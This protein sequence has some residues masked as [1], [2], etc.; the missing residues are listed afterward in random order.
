MELRS[1]Y[2]KHL[3]LA[4]SI[5]F[6]LLGIGGVLLLPKADTQHSQAVQATPAPSQSIASLP[7]PKEKTVIVHAEKKWQDTGIEVKRNQSVGISAEGKVTWEGEGLVGPEGTWFRATQ[8]EGSD[9]FP[10]PE[11]RVA[12]LVMRIGSKKYAV[13]AADKIKADEEGTIEFMINGRMF[14][15]GGWKGRFFTVRVRVQ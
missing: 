11:A 14:A 15:L 1:P 8:L 2:F 9:D 5:V 12:S 10:M 4:G 6:L 13:G 3:W 7:A